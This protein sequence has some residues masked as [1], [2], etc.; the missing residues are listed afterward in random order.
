MSFASG[1]L[2]V[3]YATNGAIPSKWLKEWRIVT[4]RA[5]AEFADWNH[6]TITPTDAAGLPPERIASDE[7]VFILQ[8]QD[9]L[10]AIRTGRPTRTPMREGARTLDLVLA[11]ARSAETHAEVCL[12]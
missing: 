11:A 8:L 4:A 10:S 7:D 6:A 3:I 9:L 5:V 1:A 12:D 2:A